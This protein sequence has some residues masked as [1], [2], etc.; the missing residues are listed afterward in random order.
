MSMPRADEET[1]TFF[2]SL[3][4]DDPPVTVRPMF[5]NI[6][7]F[8]N[9]NMFT[10]VFG[11]TVFVRLPEADRAELL[12]IEGAEP[13]EPMQGRPMREYVTLPEAW[14]ED[15][16]AAREWVLRSLRWAAALPAKESKNSRR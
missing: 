5:G 13:F 12:A 9:G 14:R 6:A 4:P 8:I 16:D 7:G 1:R 15:V 2:H 11:T 3:L 10:G